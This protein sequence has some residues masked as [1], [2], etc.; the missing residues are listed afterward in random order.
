MCVNVKDFGNTLEYAGKSNPMFFRAANFP[1]LLTPPIHMSATP[2]QN[3][4]VTISDIE[5]RNIE[6]H[7]R[8]VSQSMLS[9]LVAPFS[10]MD[11]SGLSNS[12]ITESG[13]VI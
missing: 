1:G 2:V 7:Q 10:P 12:T 6:I 4:N 5:V 11:A 9:P 3:L 8:N 13:T